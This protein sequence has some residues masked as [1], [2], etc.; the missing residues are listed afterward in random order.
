MKPVLAL[1]ALAMIFSSASS[2][3]ARAVFS[4]ASEPTGVAC[5]FDTATPVGTVRLVQMN[6]VSAAG[7]MRVSYGVPITSPLSAIRSD[8]AGKVEPDTAASDRSTGLLVAT[9][10]GGATGGEVSIRGVT[11]SLVGTIFTSPTAAV[12]TNADAMFNGG[13]RE[14]KPCKTKPAGSCCCC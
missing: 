8:S 7:S 1:V 14:E 10:P 5:A 12:T 13:S 11:V 2:V 6:G 9:M 3:L 4:L